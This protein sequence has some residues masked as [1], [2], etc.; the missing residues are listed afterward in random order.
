MTRNIRILT[1]WI[2]IIVSVKDTKDM[3]EKRCAINLC[4]AFAIA[5]KHYLRHEYSYNYDDIKALTKHLPKMFPEPKQDVKNK[6][7]NSLY[8]SCQIAP[9]TNIPLEI[10][11]YIGIYIFSMKKKEGWDPS[12]SGMM[13]A[14]MVPQNQYFSCRMLTF[15]FIA[16][17][18]A[19]NECLTGFERILRTPIPVA[20]TVHLYHVI[21]LYILSLPYQ[22]VNAL[23]WWTIPAVAIASFTCSGILAIGSEIEDPFGYDAND[24][25]SKSNSEFV[26]SIH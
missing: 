13:F 16:A 12:I 17:A 8:R 7:N 22:L 24:L 2:W 15:F 11:Y 4:L 25:V 10:S 6:S 19:L 20:Y 26:W 5:S 9:P 14:G 18:N 21:W 1:K 3:I 23:G